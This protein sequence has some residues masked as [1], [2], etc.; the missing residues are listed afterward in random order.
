[1]LSFCNLAYKEH[2]RKSREKLKSKF[3]CCNWR[4]AGLQ[5]ATWR[6]QLIGIWIRGP[7]IEVPKSPSLSLRSF[8]FR[9]VYVFVFVFVLC[10]EC[11]VAAMTMNVGEEIERLKTEITRLG[12]K[13]ADGS[14]T[15]LPSLLTFFTLFSF[16]TRSYNL[17]PPIEAQ[18]WSQLVD[19][20]R[21][22]V[23]FE[24]SE[25]V[26]QVCEELIEATLFWHHELSTFCYT[27]SLC[28][29]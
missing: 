21:E 3:G 4:G 15:V 8:C 2:W 20:R 7:H 23:C 6:A 22:G 27:T 28:Q 5:P 16:V 12:S 25:A 24:V 1:M 29:L 13:Q 19:V 10:C 18:S 17:L 26:C 11:C 14:I 9:F